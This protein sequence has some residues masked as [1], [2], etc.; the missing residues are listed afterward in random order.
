VVD[1][2]PLMTASRVIN[3]IIV[4]SLAAVDADLTV[5]QLRVLVILSAH[6]G[7]SLSA[8]AED[9]GVNPSNASR[10]CE[11]LV[12][13]GLVTRQAQPDDR[14]RVALDLSASGRLMIER[15]MDRRRQQLDIIVGEM[16]ADQQRML[17]VLLESFNAAAV[18]TGVADSPTA[19]GTD[20][21][22]RR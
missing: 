13:R 15:V 5:P 7:A 2:E 4:K 19:G 17:M 21:P 16:A 22:T 18:E 12:R 11:Q 3:A 1:V 8:V 20:L 9:L 14:R 10:T 6:P